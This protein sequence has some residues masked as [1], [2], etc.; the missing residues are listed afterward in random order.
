MARSSRNV[1]IPAFTLYGESLGP[2]VEMLHIEAIQSRSQRHRWEIDAHTHQGLHQVLWVASGPAEVFLED[3]RAACHGPL[4]VVIPP[5]AVHAF[6]FSRDTDGHVLTFNPRAVI[7]GDVPATGE[8]LRALFAAP[9]ML[10]F[11]AEAASTQ[12]IA[13]LMAD[14]SDEFSSADAAGSPVPLWLARAVVWRLAQHGAKQA[15][16]TASGGRSGQAL[17]T[18]FVVLVEAHHREHWPVSRYADRLGLTPERLNR[19]TRAET[20]KAALDL[21]HERLAREAC[22]RLAYVAAPISRLA[23]E[24]GFED[25]A[26][27]CRFFK[28]RTG[29]SPRE[30]RRAAVEAT[31]G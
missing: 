5:G 16:S 9:R 17:F 6:R 30:Y 20:G 27:F 11:E 22:R 4:A 26:Y 21:V 1:S 12:R 19:L 18:R 3:T 13:T 14:L 29:H 31:S 10:Q 2:S 24:L 15:R 7:E 28:R 23:F 25:P 8:A